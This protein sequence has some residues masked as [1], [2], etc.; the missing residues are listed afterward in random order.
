M[1]PGTPSTLFEQVAKAASP[2]EAK[3]VEYSLDD[4]SNHAGLDKNILL[5]I[6]KHHWIQKDDLDIVFLNL[7]T[8]EEQNLYTP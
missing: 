7:T 3:E 6:L 8:T 2:L 4:L 5:E 1:L